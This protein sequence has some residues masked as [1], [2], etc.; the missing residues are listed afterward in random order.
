MFEEVF[1]LSLRTTPHFHLSSQYIRHLEMRDVDAL[2]KH[3]SAHHIMQGL[4][5]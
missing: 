1:C 4:G 2:F 3:D 5:S